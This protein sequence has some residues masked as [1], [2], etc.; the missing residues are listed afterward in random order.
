MMIRKVKPYS[1]VIEAKD[2]PPV[3]TTLDAGNIFSAARICIDR[4]QLQYGH[5]ENMTVHCVPVTQA[6]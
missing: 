3:S 1:V 4:Y 5:P 2:R 6:D